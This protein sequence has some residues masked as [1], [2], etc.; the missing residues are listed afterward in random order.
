MK[1]AVKIS[2]LRSSFGFGVS[3]FRAAVLGTTLCQYPTDF[4][5]KLWR[6]PITSNLCWWP[7]KF[8]R[9]SDISSVP[10]SWL[11]DRHDGRR[12]LPKPQR[13]SWPRP[14]DEPP[15]KQPPREAMTRKNQSVSRNINHWKYYLGV[16]TTRV[17]FLG[18]FAKFALNIKNIA[19]PS[20][21]SVV[22]KPIAERATTHLI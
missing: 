4:A 9:R 10:S 19:F 11:R 8:D 22:A 1:K 21:L 18:R 13:L 15:F 3:W 7:Q 16:R 5:R 14:E 2:H 20:V 6:R 12:R 17:M